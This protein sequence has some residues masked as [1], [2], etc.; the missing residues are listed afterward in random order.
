MIPINLPTISYPSGCATY[1]LVEHL[2][3]QT[4]CGLTRKEALDNAN[5]KL[6][7]KSFICSLAQFFQSNQEF[8]LIDFNKEII[9]YIPHELIFDNKFYKFSKG[10]LSGVIVTP[11]KKGSLEIPIIIASLEQ[12]QHTAFV[13][14]IQLLVLEHYKKHGNIYGLANT[15]QDKTY[16][17]WFYNSLKT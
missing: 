6:T 10:G 12:N 7:P 4:Y 9:Q 15:K 14:C 5:S 11:L 17:L 3:G 8:K 1:W 16:R 13:N 2:N